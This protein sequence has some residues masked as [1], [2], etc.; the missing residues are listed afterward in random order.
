MFSFVSGSYFRGKSSYVEV[1]G[2]VL[3]GLLSVLVMIVG[4]GLCLL[5]EFITFERLRDWFKVVVREDNLYF[6]VLFLR[7]VVE[8]L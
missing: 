4:G 7:Y 6:T 1:F 3:F 8:L 5:D 2:C